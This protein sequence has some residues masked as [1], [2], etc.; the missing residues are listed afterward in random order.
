MAQRKL[1][2]VP[3]QEAQTNLTNLRNDLQ[4]HQNHAQGT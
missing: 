3:Y 4:Q 1:E 2:T